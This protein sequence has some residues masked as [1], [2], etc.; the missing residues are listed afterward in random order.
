MLQH[1][2]LAFLVGAGI[3]KDAP[4]C[5]PLGAE[6]SK[7]ILE[8]AIDRD[9]FLLRRT[10][11]LVHLA[12]NGATGC[13]LEVLLEIAQQG[14]GSSALGPIRIFRLGNP[15]EYHY[16]IAT[17]LVQGHNVVTTNFDNLIERAFRDLTGTSPDV[18]IRGRDL[19]RR[20]KSAKYGRL[21]KIHGSL[22]FPNGRN[23]LDSVQGTLSAFTGGLAAWK[24][25]ALGEFLGYRP[26]LSLGY[27]GGDSFDINPAL[28]Q[29]AAGASLI[30]T[31]YAKLPLRYSKCDKRSPALIAGISSEELVRHWPDSFVVR[32]DSAELL[33]YL[34]FTPTPR[35][36]LAAAVDW[37]SELSK[38]I[39]ALKLSLFNR[40][41]YLAKVLQQNGLWR[42]S[43]RCLDRNLRIA[44][45][46]EVALAKDDLAQY[47]FFQRDFA[48]DITWRQAAREVAR[49]FK[50][51]Q[52]REIIARTW[53]GCAEAYR[54]RAQYGRALISFRNAAKIYAR[55]HLNDKAGYSLVGIAGIYRMEGMVQDAR[56]TYGRAAVLLRRGRDLPG[57]L[58]V[59]WCVAELHKHRGEF[60]IAK[61]KYEDVHAQAIGMGNQTLAAWAVWGKAEI[62]RLVGDLPLAIRLYESARNGFYRRDISG[63]A[64]ALEGLS[65]CAIAS[66][67]SPISY[68]RDARDKFR[69]A[70]GRFG[71]AAVS[72]N[73]IKYSLARGRWGLC[74]QQL[75]SIRFPKLARKEW[76]HL[77]LLKAICSSRLL[78]PSADITFDRALE[79]YTQLDMQHGLVQCVAI[80]CSE[81]PS[82]PST[83]ERM[84]RVQRAI[85]LAVRNSYP[86][87]R[88]L[89]KSPPRKGSGLPLFY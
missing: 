56:A 69:R 37:Q 3:S 19:N 49:R 15:N 32:G 78:E 74:K 58:Y 88:L 53:L 20:R 51:D 44:K 75:Q 55:L 77:T 54:H 66:G 65:Q 79:L 64:W 45:G 42:E 48:R 10:S 61:D 33:K 40:T 25:R 7:A 50:G 4:A 38:E 1:S 81:R 36:S 35:P 34:P 21:L 73:T 83:N 22:A 9:P 72:L 46:I 41:R 63:Q 5:L 67:I 16:A 18:V 24:R 31:Q 87:V 6:V 71:L 52:S 8:G 39:Q 30:W 14:I 85:D 84:R 57:L 29:A 68:L 76:A 13:R 12:T 2:N 43:K 27:S 17:A 62:A 47:F 80:A 60:A 86:E 82:W 89:R 26:V 11:K 28:L 70:R 59:K 23:A